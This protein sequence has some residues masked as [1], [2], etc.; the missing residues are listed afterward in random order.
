MGGFEGG[1]TTGGEIKGLFVLDGRRGCFILGYRVATGI[2]ARIKSNI[3]L[4]WMR[5]L[6]LMLFWS[7][8]R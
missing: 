6:L 8:G 1:G 5:L 2:L 7:Y 4:W 3:A